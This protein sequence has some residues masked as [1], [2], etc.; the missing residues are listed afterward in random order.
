MGRD[1][2]NTSGENNPNYKTGFAANGSRQSFYNTWQ[3]MKARVNNPNHPKYHRYGGRGIALSNEWIGIEGFSK[4][5]LANGWKQGLSIDRIDNDGDYCPENCHWVTQSANSRKKSTTRITIEQAGEIRARLAKGETAVA[6]AVEF[7]VNHG[8]V[9]F[10]EKNI[11]HVAEGECTKM[12]KQKRN[13][14]QNN[15]I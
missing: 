5:A 9:W 2:K 12:L 8:T 14:S 1:Y 7:N 11:T 13:E 3:N 4:W 10:I 6:L 15:T